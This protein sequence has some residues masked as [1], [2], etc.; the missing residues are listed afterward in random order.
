MICLESFLTNGEDI[1]QTAIETVCTW[2]TAFAHML[3]NAAD[4]IS[5]RYFQMIFSDA[6]R[7]NAFEEKVSLLCPWEPIKDD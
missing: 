4:D 1:D 5:R 2:F 3:K 7:V 6:L